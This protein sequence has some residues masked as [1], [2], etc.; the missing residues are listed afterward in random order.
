MDII[1]IIKKNPGSKANEI[2]YPNKT[3]MTNIIAIKKNDF[4]LFL[5]IWSLKSILSIK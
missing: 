2:T 4:N 5:E 1:I 3:N